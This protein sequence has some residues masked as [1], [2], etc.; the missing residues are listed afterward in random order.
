[1]ASRK[2]LLIHRVTVVTECI[3][4]HEKIIATTNFYSIRP[5][6]VRCPHKYCNLLIPIEHLYDTEAVTI[7][8]INTKQAYAHI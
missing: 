1:M 7:E 8:K 4:H 6:V 5:S 3:H 2:K